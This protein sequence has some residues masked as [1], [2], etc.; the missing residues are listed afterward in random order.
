MQLTLPAPV[1]A[2][3]SA[4]SAAL[5]LAI[6]QTSNLLT[7][8][9]GVEHALKAAELAVHLADRGTENRARAL[10]AQIFVNRSMGAE[11]L[12]ILE[13]ATAGLD[14]TETNAAPVFAELARLYMMQ[15]RSGESVD[16]AE[17]ALRSAAPQRDT[18]V[19]V[20]ALVTQGSAIAN[21]GRFDEAEAIMRGAMNLADR[22]GHI[23]AALRARNNL[24]STLIVDVPQSTLL[25]LMNESVELALRFG[26]AGWGAQHLTSRAFTYLS[27]GEWEAA[28]ADL[29]TLAEWDLTELHAAVVATTRAI[30]AAAGGDEAT[31]EAA[32]VEARDL[33]RTID[34]IPQVTSVASGIAM[35][36][37][38]LG[39]WASA[40]RAVAGLEG[41]GNDPII[42]QLSSFSAAASGDREAI[43]ETLLR[44]DAL[45]KLRISNVI[46]AQVRASAAAISGRWDEA[47]AEYAATLTEYRELD[48]NLEAALLG[49]EF[50]AYLGDRFDDGRAAGAQAEAWFAE[51]G[52]Q[53][54]VERY[55]SAFRGTPAPPA[56]GATSPQ[57]A[58]PIDAEQRA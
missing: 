1:E 28:R 6:A 21:L 5:H 51:R 16:M 19:I 57:R 58:V 17:R 32:L 49:L 23:T 52:A 43:A 25:P 55:R 38:V 42:C 41:G 44:T 45:D 12:A 36:H 29:D 26:L 10:A 9:D 27:L 34:T 40:L 53:A 13:P 56:P 33:L 14:E 4:E 24:G 8:P 11:A 37:L 48:Y 31:A 3:L 7:R 50:G 2:R 15:D 46:R 20:N 35:A 30:L 54:V 47:R 39:Q 18:E 22:E